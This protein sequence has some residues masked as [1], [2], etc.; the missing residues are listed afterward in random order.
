MKIMVD[1][2]P[3]KPS[4]CLFAVREYGRERYQC[5]L[6]EEGAMNGRIISDPCV[7]GL[8]E[9]CPYLAEMKGENDA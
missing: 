7:F 5:F 4:E 1:K 8:G 9:P 3:A 6:K 2:L